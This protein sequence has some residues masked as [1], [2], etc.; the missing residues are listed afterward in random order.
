MRLKL[1]SS[2]SV[3]ISGDKYKDFIFWFVVVEYVSFIIKRG[4]GLIWAFIVFGEDI[5]SS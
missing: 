4:L 2:K 3:C 1:Q 5:K